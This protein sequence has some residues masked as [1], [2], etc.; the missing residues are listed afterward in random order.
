[1]PVIDEVAADYQDDV[2]FL[3]VGG[4]SDLAK[5]AIAADELFSD[6]LMWGY[7]PDIWALYGIP[8]QPATVLIADGVIV[9]QWFGA[10]GE[11][12]LRERLDHLVELSA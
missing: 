4:R 6:N 10:I 7:S 2:T 9:D 8:G 3:A 5:T 12:A 1:M 11:D